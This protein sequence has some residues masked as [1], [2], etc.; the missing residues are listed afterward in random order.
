MHR[1]WV[2]WEG[3]GAGHFPATMELDGE[4]GGWGGIGCQA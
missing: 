3:G 1:A 2:G 4:T